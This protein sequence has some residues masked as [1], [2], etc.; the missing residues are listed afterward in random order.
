M[1]EVRNSFVEGFHKNFL[2]MDVKSE[3]MFLQNIEEFVMDEDKIV[4]YF[5]PCVE[6]IGM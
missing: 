5:P 3:E 2:K 1:W 6:F 4:S